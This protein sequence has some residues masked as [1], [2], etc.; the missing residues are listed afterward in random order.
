MEEWVEAGKL[1]GWEGKLSK[2]HVEH[3]CFAEISV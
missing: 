2:V 3:L 1:E